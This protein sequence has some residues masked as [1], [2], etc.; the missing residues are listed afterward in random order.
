[1]A[2]ADVL[3][4]LRTRALQYY[5]LTSML[6]TN[7]LK[8]DAFYDQTRKTFL[9]YGRHAEGIKLSA[10]DINARITPEFER[11]ARTLVTKATANEGKAWVALC[12]VVLHV[13]ERVRHVSTQY[14][15]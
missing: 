5:L 1:M 14:Y 6:Y 2:D 15:N 4:S 7:P 10:A 13:A 8:L 12:E 9:L 3:L 11:L